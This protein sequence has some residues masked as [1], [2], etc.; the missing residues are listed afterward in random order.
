M[1]KSLA[2]KTFVDYYR[3]PEYK[4]RHLKYMKKKVLCECCGVYVARNNM[5]HH[6]KTKKHTVNAQ[7][8]E[9]TSQVNTMKRETKKLL[10][11]LDAI[12]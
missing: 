10:K 2:K 3:D 5:C 7:K 6:R 9:L 12:K 1:S 4:E 11:L 8:E